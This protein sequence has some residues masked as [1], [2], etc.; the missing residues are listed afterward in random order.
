MG[1]SPDAHKRIFFHRERST[2]SERQ[3]IKPLSPV[4]NIS[5]NERARACAHARVRQ[6]L[7]ACVLH[8]F[9]VGRSGV[10]EIVWCVN[11]KK[12]KNPPH[13]SVFLKTSDFGVR[14]H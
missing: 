11:L 2:E 7:R 4:K 3:D 14:D 12:K 13:I 8:N 6:R 9:F 5:L 1:F 10:K